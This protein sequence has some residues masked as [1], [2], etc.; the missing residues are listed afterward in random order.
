MVQG[1]IAAGSAHYVSDSRPE[2]GVAYLVPS[3]PADGVDLAA[4]HDE[5]T[6]IL[7]REGD[8]LGYAVSFADLDADGIPELLIQ[9]AG[10]SGLMAESGF[11]G[12]VYGVKLN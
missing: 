5:I 6:A 4:P 3:Q 8:G 2:A 12:S 9:A 11:R 1:L 10:R 7:G